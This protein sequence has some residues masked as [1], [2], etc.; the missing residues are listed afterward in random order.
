MKVGEA[1][2]IRIRQLCEER[3]ITPNKLC[4]LSGIIQ[5][6]VNSIFSGRSAN[7][8]IATI[9]NLCFG[10]QISLVEFFDCD[11]FKEENIEAE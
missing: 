11:L 7:P 5:S 10:L 9:H 6:T 2:A 1:I 8:K 4:T 3:G